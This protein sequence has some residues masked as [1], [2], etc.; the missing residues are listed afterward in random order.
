MNSKESKFQFTNPRIIELEFLLN[1][2]NTQGEFKLYSNFEVKILDK[3]ENNAFVQLIFI[4]KP[5]E[6]EQSPFIIKAIV[7]ANFKWENMSDN[8]VMPFLNTNA[9]AFLLS[10]L[11][12]TVAYITNAAGISPYNIPF[13]NFTKPKPETTKK[14]EQPK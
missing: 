5:K 11:R 2:N 4:S 14:I 1:K 10:Y 3:Q 9:P 8:L 6:N 13:M 7:E 12:P